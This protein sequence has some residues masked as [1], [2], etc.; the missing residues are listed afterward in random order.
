MVRPR[1]GLPERAAELPPEQRI[2]PVGRARTAEIIKLLEV[3]ALAVE[4]HQ[5]RV[6]LPRQVLCQTQHKAAVS[7]LQQDD[8]RGKVRHPAAKVLCHPPAAVP[9][10]L[11][12]QHGG[13]RAADGFSAGGRGGLRRRA[14]LLRRCHHAAGT[15]PAQKGPEGLPVGDAVIV[16]AGFKIRLAG[17][18]VELRQRFSGPA[19]KKIPQGPSV[20][21]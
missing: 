16:G 6:V 10:Q 11:S 15:A 9:D 20:G 7:R 14:C 8:L 3:I 18:K 1:H 17:L 13:R 19:H 21:T 2:D 12:C 5:R 4:D